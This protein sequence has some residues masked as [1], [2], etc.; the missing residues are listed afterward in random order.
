MSSVR[1]PHH[2]GATGTTAS[3]AAT[4]AL[5]AVAAA[6]PLAAAAAAGYSLAFSDLRVSVPRPRGD[7]ESCCGSATRATTSAADE[8]EVLRGVDGA[9]PSGELLCILG[10]SG[11]GK[12]TLLDV[13]AGRHKAGRVTGH[14]RSRNYCTVEIF[15]K[16]LTRFV[17]SVSLMRSN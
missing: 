7:G 14:V 6:E 17:F 9:L 10:S 8:L 13:L 4:S 15:P 16:Y 2:Y 3:A 12:T 1:P 11:A 5:D